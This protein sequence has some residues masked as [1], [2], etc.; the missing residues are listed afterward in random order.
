MRAKIGWG[1]LLLGVAPS[2]WA[3]TPHVCPEGLADVPAFQKL[4]TEHQDVIDWVFTTE[5]LFT[6]GGVLAEVRFNSCDGQG[7]P[8]TTGEGEK[9]ALG[10][11]NMIR[12]SGPEANSC[13]GC[14]AQPRAGGAGDF[15]ANTFNG[16]ESLDPVTESISAEISNERN[17]TGM[18][19]SGYLELL[20]REMTAEL[21]A[22]RDQQ[23]AAGTVGW[24]TLKTKGVS[25]RVKFDG[26]KVTQARG[27]DKDLVVKPFN[28]GGTV[29]SLRQFTVEAF[30]R[31]HGL[32]A[33]EHYDLYLG[34]PDFD[35]DGVERELTVGDITV[36]TLWQAMLDR[37]LQELPDA[38]TE[39]E[40]LATVE[41]GQDLMKDVGCTGCHKAKLTVS[42]RTFCEP[43]PHNPEGIFGDTSQQVCL[44]LNYDATDTDK[45]D[46]ESDGSGPLPGVPSADTPVDLFAYTDLKRHRMCD[47][48]EEVSDP[49]RALCGEQHPEGRPT[50]SG[51]SGTEYFITADLWHV[52]ESAP[53]GHNGHFPSL[54]SII[55][56]HAGEARESRDAFLALPV[57]DQVAIIEFLRTLKIKDQ[58][59]RV[60]EG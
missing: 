13:A 52:G 34:D 56:A 41:R 22:L 14:H 18:F 48:P 45:T 35:E 36:A 57:N 19:G 44:L 16:A 43:G 47:D 26:T 50:V 12:T 37:P 55:R 46:S 2:V 53:Y 15:V 28:H 6:L 24:V 5:E 25:F 11:P 58:N 17:T 8:A 20:A 23:I 40:L 29:V 49:I 4:H 30:N 38:D 39:A 1:V 9:R 33:E 27:I 54:G 10:Q 31:H 21:H 7:R 32:Q 3:H 51:V 60:V 59:V 42:N